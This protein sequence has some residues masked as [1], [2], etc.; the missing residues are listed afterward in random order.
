MYCVVQAWQTPDFK[1]ASLNVQWFSTMIPRMEETKTLLQVILKKCRSSAHLTLKSALSVLA[2]KFSFPSPPR[3]RLRINKSSLIIMGL[4]QLLHGTR[5]CNLKGGY[6][7]LGNFP[8][9]SFQELLNSLL[10]GPELLSSIS[11]L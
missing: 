2:W 9:N 11:T 8:F 7:T 3:I 6:L 10:C 4:T 5:Y 1:L